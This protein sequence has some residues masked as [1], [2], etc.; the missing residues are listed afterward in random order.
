MKIEVAA[1]AAAKGFDVVL[2]RY[3]SNLTGEDVTADVLARLKR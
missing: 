2:T 1:I 3:L